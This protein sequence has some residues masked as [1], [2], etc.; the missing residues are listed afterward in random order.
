AVVHGHRAEVARFARRVA[1]L[2]ARPRVLPPRQLATDVWKL[3]LYADGDYLSGSS[4]RLVHD[5]RALPTPLDVLVG[6]GSAGFVDEK[7]SLAS[8]LPLAIAL[9]VVTTLIVLFLMT[10]S[11]VLPLKALLMNALTVS[12]AFGFL[13]FVF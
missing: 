6:G 9:V 8:H 4:Q 12:A 5:I 3:D 13:V 2:P 10:G 11:L 7:S 1:A